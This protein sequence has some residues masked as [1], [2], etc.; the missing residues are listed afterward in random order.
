MINMIAHFTDYGIFFDPDNPC[1][2]EVF[3]DTFI[4]KIK[5]TIWTENHYH[6]YKGMDHI[7]NMIYKIGLDNGIKIRIKYKTD[8]DQM[9]I[10]M[11][12][13]DIKY[14][15]FILKEFKKRYRKGE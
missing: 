9:G 2:R 6:K 5:D 8:I 14:L 12:D 13:K 1:E 3:M 4:N 7:T 11:K 15:P 10:Q